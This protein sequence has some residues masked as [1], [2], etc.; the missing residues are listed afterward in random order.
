MSPRERLRVR[1]G[2]GFA[3]AGIFAFLQREGLEYVVAIAKYEVRE[4]RAARLKGTIPGAWP[5]WRRVL[6]KVEAVRQRGHRSQ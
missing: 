6:I 4:R 3:A 2:G 5:K 1:L